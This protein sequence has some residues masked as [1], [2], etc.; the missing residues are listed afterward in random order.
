MSTDFDSDQAYWFTEEDTIDWIVTTDAEVVS[1]S[2]TVQ[3]IMVNSS[4][5]YWDPSTSDAG[6]S[7]IF[8]LPDSTIINGFRYVLQDKRY[9]P[10]SFTLEIANT[11]TGP[12]IQVFDEELDVNDCEVG[13]LCT[14][15]EF[16]AEGRLWRWHVLSTFDDTSQ[17]GPLIRF[18]NFKGLG[19]S[20]DE[21]AR[22]C[23]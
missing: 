14:Y 18:A 11:T 3:N 8:Q 13:E 15:T 23:F 19:M 16:N 17:Q 10:K 7:V 22:L 9:A 21:P 5:S 6:W 4:K 20:N 12:W 2:K 1:K